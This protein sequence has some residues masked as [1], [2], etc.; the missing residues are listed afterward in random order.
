M[1]RLHAYWPEGSGT[2]TANGAKPAHVGTLRGTT[3]PQWRDGA[4]S[5]TA[6]NWLEF[7]GVEGGAV[8]EFPADA[9]TTI[10]GEISIAAQVRTSQ[11]FP[12]APATDRQKEIVARG[13]GRL[14]LGWEEDAVENFVWLRCYIRAEDGDNFE[15]EYRDDNPQPG[16]RDGEWHSIVVRF[17]PSSGSGVSD[18]RAEIWVDGVLRD[19]ETH[20]VHELGVSGVEDLW[21]IGGRVNTETSAIDRNLAADIQDVR[22]YDHYLA[23][24][25]IADMAVKTKA[26]LLTEIATL[27]ADNSAGDISAEDLRTGLND[28]VDSLSIEGIPERTAHEAQYRIVALEEDLESLSGASV[29]T[30]IEV[31]AG[32]E[33]VAVAVKVLDAVTGATTFDVQFQQAEGRTPT[34]FRGCSLKQTSTQQVNTG[35]SDMLEWDAEEYDTDGFHSIVT[36]NTRM[37]IPA[38]S[39]ITKVIVGGAFR[40]S[41][42]GAGK[43]G[44]WKN[45]G[46]VQGGPELRVAATGLEGQFAIVSAPMECSPGDYFE[47]RATNDEASN[48]TTVVDGRTYAFL[49]VVEEKTVVGLS[50]VAIADE[51]DEAAVVQSVPVAAATPI[52]LVAN[53]SNFTGGDVRVALFYR[54]AVAPNNDA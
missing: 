16:L 24:W 50:A 29:D 52:T 33:L 26:E 28:M 49:Q 9:S 43:I 1:L 14:T 51:T 53:G 17:R 31:P 47:I 37:T 34:Q 5:P 12:G 11:T 38:G 39:N 46:V 8:V 36:N 20:S 10:T 2:T 35:T 48:K 7:N 44:V 40:G 21:A 6:G 15:L 22:I 4:Y 19:A 41:V 42:W 27:F 18:G 32:G 25:E 30:T 3:L 45:G 54:I 23:D 13:G